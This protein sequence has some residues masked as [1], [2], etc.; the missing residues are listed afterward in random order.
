MIPTPA[1]RAP[2]GQN[3]PIVA[4]LDAARVQ[5]A[6][7]LQDDARN[8]CPCQC[9]TPL[10]GAQVVATTCWDR[11]PAELRDQLQAAHETYL[12]AVAS[13]V[14]GI[15][16]PARVAY[17]DARRA[18]VDYVTAHPAPPAAPVKPGETWT[19][20]DRQV[21]VLAVTDAKVRVRGHHRS[22]IRLARFLGDFT[23]V[24]D[25]PRPVS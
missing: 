16:A 14:R 8:L 20:G 11:I 2:L 17:Q 6:R 7:V 9:G 18:V 25:T 4:A 1:P 21:E 10:T 19:D 13:R 15:T 24:A 23:K 12:Q 5:L 22:T 3:H